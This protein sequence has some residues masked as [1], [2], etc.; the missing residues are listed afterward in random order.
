MLIH[1]RRSVL[2]DLL[3]PDRAAFILYQTDPR[4]RR[5]YDF[6]DV[7]E[8]KAQELFELFIAWRQEHPRQNFQAGIFNQGTGRLCGCAGLQG[9]KR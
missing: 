4:Y 8:P 2:R 1:T 9:G 6:G 5:L 7:D 3:E